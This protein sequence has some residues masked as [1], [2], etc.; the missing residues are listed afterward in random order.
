MFFIPFSYICS[1]NHYLLYVK[2]LLKTILLLLNF[3]SMLPLTAAENNRVFRILNASN[4]LVDNSAQT[5]VCTKTG[6]MIISTVGNLNFYDGNNFTHAKLRQEC[7][8]HLPLYNGDYK[9]FFDVYHHLWLKNTHIVACLD[10]M[11]ETYIQNVDS[12]IHSFGCYDRVQDLFIDSRGEPWFLTEKGLVGLKEHKLFTVMR[13][14]NLQDLDVCDNLLLTFY[15]N[16]EEMAQ[17]TLTGNIVHRTKAYDSD[18]AQHYLASSSLQRYGDGYFQL[19]KGKKGSALLFFNMAELSWTV[20]FEKDFLVNSMCLEDG[21]LYLPTEQGYM[22]YDPVTGHTDNYDTLQLNGGSQLNTVCNAITFDKQGGMWIGTELR[23][24]LYAPP[25]HTLFNVYPIGQPEGDSYVSMMAPLT[26]NI[27]DYKSEQANCK[28]VDSRGW[29]WIGTIAGLYLQQSPDTEPQLFTYREG[30]TNNVIHSIIEDK[31][32]NIWVSTSWGITFLLI[33]GNEVAFV[34][35]F[36]DTD[37]VP[38]ESFANCKAMCLDD[39]TIVMQT[40]DN[41]VTYH[42]DDFKTVNIPHAY[43]LY[44]KLTRLLVD[45]NMVYPNVELDGNIIIDR[46]VTRVR[47]IYLRNDQNSINLVFSPLNYFRPRQ[48]FYKVRIKGLVDDWKEMSY[49]GSDMIDDQGMLHLPLLGLRP[50]EYNVELYVSLFPGIWEG[51]PYVWVIH[52]EQSWWLTRG[53]F[54]VL[55]VLLLALLLVNFYLY[56]KNTRMR[57]RRNA[58]EG[59]IIRK[60]RL[61]VDRCKA[62]SSEELVPVKEEI[63]G[64]K[65]DARMQLSPEFIDLMLKLIPYVNDNQSR[66]LTMRQL[67]DVGGVEIVRL[68]DILSSNIYKSPRDL[69]RLLRLRKSA[70]LLLTTDMTIEQISQTC[71]FYT[72]N[73]FMGNFFNEYKQT[74]AEY[75]RNKR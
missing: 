22:V 40:L 26:Q 36:T 68:Y 62:Y 65:Y 27:T 43:K 17:D 47:D 18:I 5:L 2:L 37:N 19:R 61:F 63:I 46:A 55:G 39:G 7:Q 1:R 74:P 45:G 69:S 12:V 70:R 71:G 50:G 6:R 11:L 48:S 35:G 54:Y 33:R 67:S 73:Y 20:L 3:F 15:D 52:V 49:A 24:L 32:H 56:N 42:P 14:H 58:E 29:T 38:N 31:D 25:M 72:P 13:D 28:Y 41:V 4:G 53:V 51:K 44:P 16:G 75:R 9:M 10:L 21:L 60:I 34:N 8:Y 30:L 57:A 66:L 59:D 64:G 23:G